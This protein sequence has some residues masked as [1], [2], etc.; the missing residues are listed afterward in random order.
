MGRNGGQWRLSSG[1]VCEVGLAMGG[2]RKKYL[3]EIDGGT[4]DSYVDA[5]RLLVHVERSW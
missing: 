1:M 3:L 4:L 2:T 5:W